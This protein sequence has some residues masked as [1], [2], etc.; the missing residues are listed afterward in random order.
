LPGPLEPVSL[1]GKEIRLD[2]LGPHHAAALVAASAG[3]PSLYCWTF[4]PRDMAAAA[5]YIDTALE[6]QQAG[7]SVPFAVVRLTDGTVIGSTRF[8]NIERWPWPEGHE[9]HGRGAPDVCEIGYTWFASS[10]IRTRANTEAKYL[11]LRHAFEEWGVVRVSL[12]TDLRNLRSQAAIER[13]GAK[14]EG[15]LRAQRLGADNAPRDSV[16]YS[17]LASEWPEVCAR[18]EGFLK[19]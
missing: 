1:C 7:T 2:P 4:V 13:L 19:Q 10:A 14:K 15:V 6:W 8:F 16:R 18:L 17:I 5:A 9:R 3:D 12:Q 11:M